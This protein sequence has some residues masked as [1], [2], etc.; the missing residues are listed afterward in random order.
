VIFL[1]QKVAIG[2]VRRNKTMAKLEAIRFFFAI[3]SYLRE[4]HVYFSFFHKNKHHK[5]KGKKNKFKAI[6]M[7]HG[8]F[9]D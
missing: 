6:I 4:I 9:S 3:T 8:H 1:S 2:V 5:H 7:K